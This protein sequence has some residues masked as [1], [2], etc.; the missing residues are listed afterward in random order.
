MAGRICSQN[1]WSEDGK[2]RQKV[3]LNSSLFR[4]LPSDGGHN[5][6]N[7]VRLHAQIS[8]EIHNANDHSAFTMTTERTRSV[9]LYHIEIYK[10]IQ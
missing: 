10:R 2:Q 3:I 8:S 6:L 1:Y 5:D 9:N 4:P 7:R